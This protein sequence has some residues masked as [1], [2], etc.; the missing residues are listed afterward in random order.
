MK[1]IFLAFG[2][3]LQGLLA[4]WRDEPAFRQELLIALILV[5]L[6]LWL[7]PDG[8]ALA[9]MLGSVMFV[10]VVELLNTAIEATVNRIGEERHP[11]AKKAKDVASAAVLLALVNVAVIWAAV[12]L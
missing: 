12:L 10:L 8:L 1:R 5:P 6:A 9:L 2:Y 7:A 4:A 11:L 3:S